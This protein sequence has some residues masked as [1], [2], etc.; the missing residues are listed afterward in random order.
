MC[1]SS[2]INISLIKLEKNVL[3]SQHKVYGVDASL[4]LY[5]D[6]WDEIGRFSYFYCNT[7]AI[8]S[9]AFNCQ[10]IKMHRINFM[11]NCIRIMEKSISAFVAAIFSPTK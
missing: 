7:V 5:N 9:W 6:L 10:N 2:L 4:K 3:K 1:Q 8:D 11:K